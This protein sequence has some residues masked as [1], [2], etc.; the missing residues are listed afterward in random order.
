MFIC[1]LVFVFNTA[2]A[3]DLG[4]TTLEPS[5]NTIRTGIGYRDLI[6]EGM[7]GLDVNLMWNS[8]SVEGGD[9]DYDD[10]V[11]APE[12]ALFYGVGRGADI[13]FIGKILSVDSEDEDDE[14]DIW[15][16]GV[17]TRYWMAV[18][19]D[20]IPYFGAS[21]NYYSL[22]AGELDNEDGSFGLA[23]EAG[24]AYLITESAAIRLGLQMETL[25]GDADAEYGSG[26]NAGEGTDIS[27][28][29]FSF[30]LGLS[31]LF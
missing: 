16:L 11:W 2:Y 12:I 17:G 18:E 26:D 5:G 31:L 14:I 21:L 28:S 8:P 10:Q 13:R 3:A 27:L 23:G 15:R 6:S 4:R 20:F 29:M 30:G 1:A 22:D 19:S 24:L 7:V 25:L 9:I